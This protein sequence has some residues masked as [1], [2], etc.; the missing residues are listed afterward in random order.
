MMLVVMINVVSNDMVFGT[1]YLLL[2]H[3]WDQRVVGLRVKSS[4][5]YVHFSM[6][7]V[8]DTVHVDETLVGAIVTSDH[9]LGEY[10]Q[11]ILVQLIK[12]VVSACLRPI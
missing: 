1:D 2:E 8:A 4:E 6:V 11:V 10:I 7:C 5:A 3:W 9:L 12:L